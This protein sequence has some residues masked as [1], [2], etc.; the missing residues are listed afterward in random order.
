MEAAD[1]GQDVYEASVP[2][3]K[4]TVLNEL[5]IYSLRLPSR[6]YGLETH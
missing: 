6:R 5:P 4:C 2:T 1:A 3:L